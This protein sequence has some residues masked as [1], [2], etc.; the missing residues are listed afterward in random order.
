MLGIDTSADPQ[1]WDRFASKIAYGGFD[2][3]WNW[4]GA[5]T[6]SRQN[7]YR[8][9]VIRAFGKT[10]KA[11]RISWALNRWEIP[12]GAV[13]CHRCDNPLCVNPGHLF[14]G[15]QA[16]NVAD[17]DRK[18]RRRTVSVS[19]PRHHNARLTTDQVAEAKNWAG[20]AEI[21]AAKFGVSATTI[22]NIRRGL[23]RVRG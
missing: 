5:S 6:P 3:C 7:G 2:E 20:S 14:L 8:F 19:G 13:V 22:R 23:V 16:D 1:L 11:S 4:T 15:T 9:G 12:T 21:L 10:M 18:G 17:M